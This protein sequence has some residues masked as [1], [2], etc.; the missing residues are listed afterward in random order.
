MNLLFRL[1]AIP[2]E[3][4]LLKTMLRSI[5]QFSGLFAKSWRPNA[6]KLGARADG[7]VSSLRGIYLYTKAL[8]FSCQ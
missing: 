6:G 3:K 8:N 5:M 7:C 1:R 2:S 4:Q